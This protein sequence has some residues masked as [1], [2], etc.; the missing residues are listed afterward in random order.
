[1]RLTELP[2][3]MWFPDTPSATSPPHGLAFP[4]VPGHLR[5]S[6]FLLLG[7]HICAHTC[8]W[9]HITNTKAGE[10]SGN[11]LIAVS[12]ERRPMKAF[13]VLLSSVCA[14][15]PG[16]IWSSACPVK[17][18]SWEPCH[19]CSQPASHPVAFSLLPVCSPLSNL[20]TLHSTRGHWLSSRTVLSK[21][22]TG[23]M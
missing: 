11:F 16:R 15:S 18:S 8:M 7:A 3:L 13:F 4:H 12:R 21:I 20:L 10:I 5:S 19:R 22:A 9:A 23:K 17:V 2:H 1:M 14:T 6:R